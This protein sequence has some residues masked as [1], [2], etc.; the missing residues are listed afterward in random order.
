MASITQWTWVWVNSR[1][2]RWTGRT[3]VLQSMGSQRVGHDWATELNWTDWVLFSQQYFWATFW[4]PVHCPILSISCS[5]NGFNKSLLNDIPV[6]G[7]W[8]SWCSSWP[9][10][11]LSDLPVM[12]WAVFKARACVPSYFCHIQLCET[13]LTIACQ[14]PLSM[15]FSTQEHW[16][17]WPCPP[18]GDVPNPR[19][20]PCL[21]HY[22]RI[23]YHWATWEGQ[24]GNNHLLFLLRLWCELKYAAAAAAAKSLQSCPTQCDP[25]D[26][27]PGTLEWVAMSF[28]NA[29]KWKVKVKPL[30]RVWLFATPWTAAYQ[31]PPSL[32][33]SRQEYWSGLPLPSPELEYSPF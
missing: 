13:P 26:S 32:G 10:V 18:Q 3:N 12:G 19:I 22:R 29:G 2:W 17:G 27:S 15:G 14:A 31:A 5:V 20:E 21:P 28:S 1:S 4:H 9:Q 6:V 25:I 23:L 7:T 8:S 24:L 11:F 16:S 33:F 30:I